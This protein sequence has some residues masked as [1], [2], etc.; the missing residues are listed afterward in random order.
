MTIYSRADET[1]T[2]TVSNNGEGKLFPM[3]SKLFR[4]KEQIC[5]AWPEFVDGRGGATSFLPRMGYRWPRPRKK[6]VGYYLVKYCCGGGIHNG[7]ASCTLCTNV[8]LSTQ[9]HHLSTLNQPP[10]TIRIP[11]MPQHV[12]LDERHID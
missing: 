9:T 7:P 10:N 1:R 6:H 3:E 4:R 8:F 12:P 11:S 5:P 2:I